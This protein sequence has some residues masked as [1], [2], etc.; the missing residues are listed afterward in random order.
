MESPRVAYI[1]CGK[2][3]C[4][5]KTFVRGVTIYAFEHT[6]RLQA[7]RRVAFMPGNMIPLKLTCPVLAWYL[8][9]PA[10]I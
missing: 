7:L 6:T 8:S 2:L 9:A 1:L 3:V 5:I 4:N 10:H